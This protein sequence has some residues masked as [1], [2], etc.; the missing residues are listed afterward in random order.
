MKLRI[1]SDIHVEFFGC[2]PPP[3]DADAIILAGDIGAGLRG[4]E[5]A[6]QEF[7]E[8]GVPVIYVPGN[9]E[10]YGWQMEDWQAKAAALAAEKGLL[11]GDRTSFRL[12]KEDEQPVRVLAAT[13]WTDFALFG[14]NHVEHCGKLTQRALYDYTAIRYQGAVLRWQDT[15]ALHAQTISW[16]TAECEMAEAAGE[17]VV[18]ITHH[19]PS[20]QSSLPVYLNDPVT[21]GFA[22]NLEAFAA[23]HVDLWVHG[24][25]HNSSNYTLGRCRVVANPR[26]YPHQKWNPNTRFENQQFNPV[27]VVEV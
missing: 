24:H 1:L 4:L 23:K 2:T 17:K 7:G 12:A 18:V 15:K 26:G 6:A 3:A 21:A 10:F 19:S 9:H 16:L 14:E 27:L 11:L 20:I 25:M 22:S 5:W 13:L 8:T